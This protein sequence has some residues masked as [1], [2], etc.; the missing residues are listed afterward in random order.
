MQQAFKIL[1]KND[2][3]LGQRAK[4]RAEILNIQLHQTIEKHF[5]EQSAHLESS[6]ISLT[7]QQVYDGIYGMRY[8]LD[9]GIQ[10]KQSSG[11][12][13]VQLVI[14]SIDQVNRYLEDE[15]AVRALGVVDPYGGILR[16]VR[17]KRNCLAKWL[18]DNNPKPQNLKPSLARFLAVQKILRAY[19]LQDDDVLMCLSVLKIKNPEGQI[20]DFRLQ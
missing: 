11:N 17:Y 20:L 4:Q 10:A 18:I 2:Q 8:I 16:E 15:L 9:A 19:P 13:S 6:G 12:D 3:A 14:E 5:Q 7:M 1:H